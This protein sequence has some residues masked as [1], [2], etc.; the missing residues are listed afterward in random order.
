MLRVGEKQGF[1]NGDDIVP[2]DSKRV[3]QE[4][5]LSGRAGTVGHVPKLIAGNS[6]LGAKDSPRNGFVALLVAVRSFLSEM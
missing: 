3:P 5:F 6:T 2:K 4:R 1:E